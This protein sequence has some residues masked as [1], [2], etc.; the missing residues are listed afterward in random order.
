MTDHPPGVLG[1]VFGLEVLG[2]RCPVGGPLDIYHAFRALLEC[3]VHAVR[4]PKFL[5]LKYQHMKTPKSLC[6]YLDIPLI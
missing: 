1:E 6:L 5:A 3:E 4:V 2:S